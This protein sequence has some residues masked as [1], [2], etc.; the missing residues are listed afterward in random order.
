MN[1]S[2][3]AGL[4]TTERRKLGFL[5]QLVCAAYRLF[6]HAFHASGYRQTG[7]QTSQPG[8]ILCLLPLQAEDGKKLHQNFLLD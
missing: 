8:Y 6:A 3:L 1:V 5:L 2:Y 7:G 4:S